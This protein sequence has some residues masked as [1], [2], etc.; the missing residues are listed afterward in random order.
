M[1][2]ILFVCLV[3]CAFPAHAQNHQAALKPYLTEEVVAMAYLDLAKIDTLA[4]LEFA[5]KLGLGPSQEQRGQATRNLLQVQDLLDQYAEFG[6]R[7][8]YALFRV[9]D[10]THGGPTWVVPIEKGGNP[11]AVKG[12]MLSGKL[13]QFEVLRDARPSF[14]PEYCEVVDTV[15][16][17]ANSPE[18]LAMLKDSEPAEPRDLSDAWKTLGSAHCGLIIFG[19]RDSRR[20]V[21]EMFPGLPEPFQKIGGP[22]IADHIRW[23]GLTVNFPPEPEFQ[24]IVQTTDDNDAKRLQQSLVDGIRKLQS[25]PLV[26]NTLSP[27]GAE[28]LV[29]HLQPTVSDG[30]CAILSGELVEDLSAVAKLLTPPVQAARRSAQRRTRK[31]RF[32]QIALA[33]LNYES[34]RGTYP[35]RCTVDEEGK[36]LLSWRVHILP[37][38]GE[39]EL[40]LYKRLHLDEP[41]D[42]EHNKQLIPLMPE[43]YADPGADAVLAERNAVGRTTYVVPTGPGTLFENPDGTKIRDVTDG[44]SNTIL[45]VEIWS[46]AGPYW[47]R[48][49]DWFADPVMPWERLTRRDQR[50]EITA[51]FCDGSVRS[52]STSVP[53][54]TLKALVSIAG[55]EVI[56]WP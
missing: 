8:V 37:Y 48:P 23:A 17:G 16:L 43:V 39:K 31:N 41:W 21:R 38:M 29:K 10:V 51:A 46:M 34:A 9:S 19:D 24:L 22:W 47:T 12:L 52:L 35:P 40:A 32:K 1:K 5:E 42:S 18:Q 26:R 14:L 55:G 44:T 33:M 3:L 54:E 50:D 13:D 30:Q 11:M 28:A 25:M 56:E 53:A 6:T 2:Q 45:L 15:V 49:K 27:E 4:A 7:Y 36:P 20:V